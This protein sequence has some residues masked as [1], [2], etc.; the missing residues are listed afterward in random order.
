[1]EP[2]IFICTYCGKTFNKRSNC[3]RHEQNVHEK[4]SKRDTILD[5]DFKKEQFVCALCDKT[6]NWKASLQRHFDAVHLSTIGDSRL[7]KCHICSYSTSYKSCLKR[8]MLLHIKI[9]QPKIKEATQFQCPH[10]SCILKK[11]R[12]LKYHIDKYHLAGQAKST[13]RR[14]CCLCSQMIYG[15]SLEVI[16]SHFEKAHNI[17]MKWEHHRFNSMSDFEFWKKSV[18]KDTTSAYVLYYSNS[19]VKVYKC[20]RSGMYRKRGSNK[21]AMKLI[22]SCKINTFCPSL[23]RVKFKENNVLVSYLPNHVGHKNELKHI[24]LRPEERK[25]IAYKL[26]RNIPHEEILKSIRE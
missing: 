16:R 14:K 22:G 25:L 2:A 8:H 18:E 9:K 7:Y 6:Y 19:S 11:R 24:H 12:T 5:Q 26:A 4:N 20:H 10:C 13:F 3:T 21:R 1:M 17:P 23:I 15:H